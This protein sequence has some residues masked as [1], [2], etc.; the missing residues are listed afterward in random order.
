MVREQWGVKWLR[1]RSRGYAAMVIA[2]LVT[3]EYAIYK[4]TRLLREAML[5]SA[6]TWY[7]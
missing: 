5:S 6:L 3:S 1:A 2:E 7:T 4:V